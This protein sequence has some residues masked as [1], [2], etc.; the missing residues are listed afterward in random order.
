MGRMA[1]LIAA[2]AGVLAVTA[3]SVDPP[4]SVE[5]P[6]LSFDHRAPIAL[7]VAEVM[8]EQAYE[9]RIGDGHVEVEAPLPPLDALRIWAR[10]RLQA[11]G[12]TGTARLTIE[13]ASLVREAL[14]TEKGLKGLFKHEASERYTGTVRVRLEILDQRGFSQAE[15]TAEARRSRSVLENA[16]VRE[17]ED[18]LYAMTAAMVADLDDKVTELAPQYLGRWLR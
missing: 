7:D 8:V 17:R 4:P 15:V 18:A 5:R 10:Q 11:A 14:P 16:S 13:E 6:G 12:G 3:C 1:R 9:P 2:L